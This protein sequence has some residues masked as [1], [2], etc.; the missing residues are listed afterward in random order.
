MFFSQ[1]YDV[2]AACAQDKRGSRSRIFLLV[3]CPRCLKQHSR[4]LGHAVED[5]QVQGFGLNSQALEHRGQ[6]RLENC[7]PLFQ[8]EVSQRWMDCHEALAIFRDFLEA[9][10]IHVDQVQDRQAGVGEPPTATQVRPDTMG[11]HLCERPLGI[12]TNDGTSI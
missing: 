11:E 5:S 10:E 9:E 3:N 7:L 6:N 8:A 12:F 4:F 2:L 1:R